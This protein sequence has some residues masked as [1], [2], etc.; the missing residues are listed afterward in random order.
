MSEIAREQQTI[1]DKAQLLKAVDFVRS[2]DC[3]MF[4]RYEQETER[5]SIYIEV[6]FHRSI[7]S[8]DVRRFGG[9]LDMELTREASHVM[10]KHL[11]VWE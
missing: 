6:S 1:I 2:F 8:I 3:E 5:S 9:A 10:A 7:F 4:I 11:G